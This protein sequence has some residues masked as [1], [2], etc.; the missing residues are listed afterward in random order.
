[1]LFVFMRM[2]TGYLPDE[3]QGMLAIM[4]TLPS[5]STLEQTGAVMEKVR[6]YFTEHEKIQLSPS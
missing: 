5:G 3:D 4:A 2:P 1:M 6:Q